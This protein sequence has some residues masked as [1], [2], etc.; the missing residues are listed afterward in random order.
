MSEQYERDARG[1]DIDAGL[2]LI[3]GLPLDL[4]RPE[5][6][7]SVE[8]PETASSDTEPKLLRVTEVATMLGLT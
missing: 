2:K 1:E 6:A 5:R 8:P 7:S 3:C 4:P